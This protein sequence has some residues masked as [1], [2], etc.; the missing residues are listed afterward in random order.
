MP[1]FVHELA[2]RIH[3][4]MAPVV[5]G[6]DPRADALPDAIAAPTVPDRIVAFYRQVLPVLARH[7]PV[8]KP[9]IAFF[10]AHGS[11]GYA[12][13]EAVCALAKEQGLL[14]LGDVKRG[15]IGST[16][17]AYAAGHFALADALTLH[18]YLGLDSVEPFLRHCTADGGGKGVFV[19][20][21]TSNPGARDFQDLRVGEHALCDVVADAVA[22]WGR[23]LPSA[24][25]Y[26]P[27]GAVVGATYPKDLARLR[28]RLPNAWLLLPGVGAQGA[29]VADLAPAFDRRGLGAL[30]A[31][32]RGVLQAFAPGESR[33]L[34]RIDA[35]AAAFAQECR[36]VARS[37]QDA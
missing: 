10:E 2:E 23:D 34:Q 27:V 33:W 32:S 14:V 3:R 25:G 12:A 7:A 8:V 21:R 20:V 22:R 31:Q 37:A 5:L 6:L 18:P 15:D 36:T 29:A 35:A 24:D 11:R 1:S 19:L 30:V 4:G 28:A 17:E 26:S 16:A 13:Y 9:N